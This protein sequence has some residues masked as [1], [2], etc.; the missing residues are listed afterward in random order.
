MSGCG[1]LIY[2]MVAAIVLELAIQHFKL[3]GP[4]SNTVSS[5]AGSIIGL[6]IIGNLISRVIPSPK[7]TFYQLQIETASASHTLLI[8]KDA[9]VAHKLTRL[10]L[11]AI[12]DP[13]A[14]FNMTVKNFHVGNNYS[15]YGD[16]SHI[17]G[18]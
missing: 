2:G 6:G 1:L 16:G 18:S 12:S 15:T 8:V 13:N 3:F 14:T 7:R 10:I 4:E 9:G 11:N 5:I 17:I